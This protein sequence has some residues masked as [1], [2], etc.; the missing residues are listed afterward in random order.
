MC[1]GKTFSGYLNNETKNTF[2]IITKSGL[3]ILPKDQ[4]R[5]QIEI[6]N[7]LITIEG[8]QLKGRHEDRIKRRMKRKW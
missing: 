1:Y 8:T 6:N 4:A 7:Q 2:Q 5:V 3:K